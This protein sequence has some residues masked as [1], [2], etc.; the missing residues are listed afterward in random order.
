MVYNPL[1]SLILLLKWSEMGPMVI[2]LSY[3]RC[4]WRW[5][6]ILC[7]WGW[8]FWDFSSPVL[9][10][11]RF[12]PFVC[13]LEVYN[14]KPLSFLIRTGFRGGVMTFKGQ[15]NYTAN[16]QRASYGCNFLLVQDNAWSGPIFLQS[17]LSLQEPFSLQYKVAI[18]TCATRGHCSATCNRRCLAKSLISWLANLNL[19]TRRICLFPKDH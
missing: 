17:V 4:P 6:F 5:T 7:P 12:T 9:L 1:L 13:P 11:K 2:P 19:N 16:V 8:T 15:D 18:S 3:V 10:S 14:T